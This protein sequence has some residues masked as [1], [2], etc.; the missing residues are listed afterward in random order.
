MYFFSKRFLFK[1]SY[2]R[3]ELYD[4]IQKRIPTS[5]GRYYFQQ[6]NNPNRT[7]DCLRS[8]FSNVKPINETRK[9][10]D[11]LKNYQFYVA[12]PKHVFRIYLQSEDKQTHVCIIDPASNYSIVEFSKDFQRTSNIG[13][14][15]R[16][17]L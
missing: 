5:D 6:S 9:F 7:D 11:E 4:I 2:S 15:N 10:V 1:Q 12:R 13:K 17:F 16:I 3:E 14:L 8:S